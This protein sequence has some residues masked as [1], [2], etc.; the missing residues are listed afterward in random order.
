M[1]H[2]KLSHGNMA[3]LQIFATISVFLYDRYYFAVPHVTFLP[4]FFYPESSD[5]VTRGFSETQN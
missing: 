5:Y 4:V 2:P 1:I 3:Y